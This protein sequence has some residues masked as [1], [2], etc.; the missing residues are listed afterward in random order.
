MPRFKAIY[1]CQECGASSPK[2]MGRCPDCGKWNTIVEEA[3]EFSAKGAGKSRALTE[4]SSE[5]TRLSDAEGCE[6]KRLPTGLPELD[7]LLGGGMVNGQVLLLAGPPGIGKSTLMLQAVEKTAGSAVVLYVSGEES[8]GQ[9]RSRAA[10][11]DIKAGGLYLLSENNLG[12]IINAFNRLKPAVLV[13]DSIQTVF[14]PEYAGSPGSVGQVRE[15]AAELLRVC[16]S[17]GASLFI[18]GHVTK[19]G[20]LA[21]PRVLEHIVDTV[22]YFDTEKNQILR[23]LRAHKNRFGPTSEV[24]IFEMGEKGLSAVSD[25]AVFFTSGHRDKAV[26]GRAFSVAME[27]TRPILT[28]LQAL[29]SPTRYPFP[30]RMVTGLDL[31]RTQLMLAA[32]EKHLRLPLENKDVFVSLA[33]G[34]KFRDAA[35]DLALCAAVI[36]SVRDLPVPADVVFIG[37]TGILGRVARVSWLGQRVAEAHRLGFRKAFIPCVPAKELPLTKTLEAVMVESLEELACLLGG[38]KLKQ[39]K[40]ATQEKQAT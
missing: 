12:K 22:L 25:A 33:G 9:V 37:E 10:R 26:A 7:R 15:C 14:H 5:V 1:R 40:Q 39:A 34:I 24:G 17:S 16:K 35:L 3:E 19:E 32:M 11:L 18:L 2:W 29:A 38:L 23:L 4:F 27:G 8:L 21:G 36:S 6:E 30:R 28:E 20:A 13:L 31:N